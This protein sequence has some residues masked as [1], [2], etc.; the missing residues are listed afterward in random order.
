M[1]TVVRALNSITMGVGNQRREITP[2]QLV[3]LDDETLAELKSHN[4]PCIQDPRDYDREQRDAQKGDSEVVSQVAE[5]ERPANMNPAT[6]TR[7]PVK[8]PIKSDP[9]VDRG[10]PAADDKDDL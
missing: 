3:E 5:P 4:P 7:D 2:G 6:A 8:P 10:K 9:N 1:G